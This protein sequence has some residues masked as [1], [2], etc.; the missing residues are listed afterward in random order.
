MPDSA[1][2]MPNSHASPLPSRK[3]HT[4]AATLMNMPIS[5]A[6]FLPTRLDASTHSGMP[7]APNTK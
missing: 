4:N 2:T 6:F 7:K 3:A 5:H 1:H